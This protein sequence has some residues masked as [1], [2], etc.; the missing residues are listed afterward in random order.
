V[1]ESDAEL[2]QRCLAGAE[3]AH[4]EF[5]L[6]YQKMIFSLCYRMLGNYEDAEDAAQE[7]LVRAIKSL[8]R[9]DPNRPMKPWLLTIAANRCRT[10]LMK[11]KR[12]PYATDFPQDPATFD[13]GEE[14]LDLAEELDLA[15]E[16]LKPVHRECFLLFHEQQLNCAE[17]GEVLG[18][19]EGT[20]KTWLHRTRK[21]LAGL[22]RQRGIVPELSYEL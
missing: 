22:L 14:R 17:V 20:I 8:S 10:A 1:N 16:Q 7:S 18:H 19:P 6:R 2:V 5:V 9:W 3:S 13:A 15:L 11:R 4:R 21:Q 12:R